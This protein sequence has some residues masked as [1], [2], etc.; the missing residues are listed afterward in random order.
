MQVLSVNVINKWLYL[1]VL[2][3]LRKLWHS[4][5]AFETFPCDLH[6]KRNV[7]SGHVLLSYFTRFGDKFLRGGG[8]A[9]PRHNLQQLYYNKITLLG[10]NPLNIDCIRQYSRDASPCTFVIFRRLTF[11]LSV[12]K[13][14]HFSTYLTFHTVNFI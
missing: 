12:S 10:Q 1:P 3:S 13:I 6:R 7:N 8:S 4:H 11:L 14:V 2:N 9:V 5:A